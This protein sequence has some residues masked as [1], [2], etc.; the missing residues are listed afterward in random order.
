MMLK[1]WS[2]GSFLVG[3]NNPLKS[4]SASSLNWNEASSMLFTTPVWSFMSSEESFIWWSH[5]D[6]NP[7]WSPANARKC[8]S[9]TTGLLSHGCPILRPLRH[10]IIF[11]GWNLRTLFIWQNWPGKTG[12]LK[13]L[14]SRHI[15]R[16]IYTPSEECEGLSCKC[17]FKLLNFLCKLT[18]LAGQF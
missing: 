12:H 7:E 15:S 4:K 18:G 8:S 17:S 14:T 6:W 1:A 5:G 2:L 9:V 11:Q 16:M 3:K 13:G 10:N